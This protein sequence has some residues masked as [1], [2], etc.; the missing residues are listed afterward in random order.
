MILTN[1]LPKH[2]VILI[3]Y[4]QKNTISRAIDSLINQSVLPFEII[5]GD[6]HSTDGTWDIILDYSG[7]YKELIIPVRT[8]INLGIYGNMNNLT[9]YVNGDIVTYLGGDDYYLNGI[10]ESLNEYILLKKL[11]I[12]EDKFFFESPIIKIY[13]DGIK[14]LYKTIAFNKYSL[15]QIFLRGGASAGI[16]GISKK[17]FFELEPLNEDVGLW[18][19]LLWV[20]DIAYKNIGHKNIYIDKPFYCYSVGVGV[21]KS[22]N[23]IK[24]SES[25]LGVTKNISKTYANILLKKDIIYIQYLEYEMKYKLNKKINNY[26]KFLKYHILNYNNLLNSSNWVDGFKKFISTKIKKLIK[27]FI[28]IFYNKKIG[29]S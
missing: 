6:D 20:L 8:E 9:Q 21:T 26:F 3:T 28:K 16:I 29:S 19:D 25:F 4:N 10:F 15:F 5:I 11:S 24:F 7:R 27:D 2:S 18:A 1:N 17:L 22:E 23:K 14:S 13:G 12:I